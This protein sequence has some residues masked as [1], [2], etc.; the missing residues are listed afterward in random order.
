MIITQAMARAFF[1]AYNKASDGDTVFV[2]SNGSVTINEK[3]SAWMEIRKNGNPLASIEEAFEFLKRMSSE[4]IR[5]L[6]E[7]NAARGKVKA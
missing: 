2:N 5:R 7:A 1:A 3:Q 4:A 6:N